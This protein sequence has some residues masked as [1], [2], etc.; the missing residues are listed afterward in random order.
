V[1]QRGLEYPGASLP[2]QS[3]LYIKV[4]PVLR[5]GTTGEDWVVLKQLHLTAE[6]WVRQ[7]HEKVNKEF[8]TFPAG[9]Y[10][11][12]LAA[13]DLAHYSF[14]DE[15]H[16]LASKNGAK[17]KEQI[18]LRNLALSEE[19]TRTFLDETLKNDKQATLQS[20]AQITVHHFARAN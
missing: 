18:V 7:W 2:K 6:Q 11:V 14:S 5:P 17:E 19:I 3:I 20:S 1:C 15:V 4:S 12:E 8:R 10:F 13:P 16:L 9:G